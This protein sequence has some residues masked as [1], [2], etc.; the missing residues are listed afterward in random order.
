MVPIEHSN[1]EWLKLLER[2]NPSFNTAL[3]E[4]RCF[5]LKGLGYS[6]K[7][8][9]RIKRD[10]LEDF[11]QEALLKILDK[12]DTFSG[13]ARFTTWAM[14]VAVNLVLSE[15][16]RK[17]WEDISLDAMKDP[18]SFLNTR[19]GYSIFMS[20]EKRMMRKEMAGMCNS[21][22]RNL[23]T[24]KQRTALVYHMKYGM[25]LDEVAR[26]LGSNRNSI[27][28]LLHD[29][30]KKLKLELSARGIDTADLADLDEG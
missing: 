30:R 9:K 3:E 6:F 8:H 1:E 17:S 25:P 16:R 13:K 24:E 15:L 14:K 23:L 20:P 10:I 18:E 28:K 11:C 12:K 27:Y 29:A 7:G 21:M 26:R 19:K 2:E 5:L 4:L 22:I